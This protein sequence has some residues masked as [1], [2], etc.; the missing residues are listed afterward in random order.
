MT[1]E[2]SGLMVENRG[3]EKSTEIAFELPTLEIGLP[4]LN[5][6]KTCDHSS[7]CHMRSI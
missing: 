4:E 1:G 3:S 6:G 5:Q 7:G 2:T